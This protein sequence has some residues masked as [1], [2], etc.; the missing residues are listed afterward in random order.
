MKK[1]I[2]IL[3][4]SV[5]TY[6]QI[7]IDDV[8]S[9]WKTKIEQALTIIQ[10]NDSESYDMVKKYCKKITYIISTFSTTQNGDTIL[11]TT[12]DMNNVSI[13]NIAAIIVHESFHL[14]A[15]H[16]NYGF[17]EQ[18]EEFKAYDVELNFLKKIPNVEPWLIENA[19][20]KRV[21]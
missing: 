3:L 2:F 12:K 4:L 7:K 10:N 18:E 21:N 20:L 9:G 8:G 1:F 6:G 15:L 13:N 16:N 17:S 14:K 5:N 11:I 19:K